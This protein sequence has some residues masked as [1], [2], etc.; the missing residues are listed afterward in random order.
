MTRIHI[1]NYF[2]DVLHLQSPQV[3]Q[4]QYIQILYPCATPPFLIYISYFSII[5][6]FS[7]QVFIFLLDSKPCWFW[8]HIYTVFLLCIGSATIGVETL[9][10][11]DESCLTEHLGG[12]PGSLAWCRKPLIICYSLGLQPPL[13][14]Q[15]VL[16]TVAILSSF[17][18]TPTVCSL[19]SL[20]P[21]SMFSLF[22][23]PFF[24]SSYLCP[25]TLH[26]TSPPFKL[27]YFP[28]FNSFRVFSKTWVLPP[29][30][31]QASQVTAHLVCHSLCCCNCRTYLEFKQFY[32]FV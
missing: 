2:L 29:S 21:L 22:R 32:Y 23:V 26:L 16:C 24:I 27:F 8:P 18:S 28:L 14:P 20:A 15:H 9:I 17:G 1:F 6:Y 31:P 3:F 12:S 5:I 13:L 7:F 4:I 11:C 25:A 19:K 10:F 30:T